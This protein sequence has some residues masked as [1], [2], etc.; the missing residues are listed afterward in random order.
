MVI[1]PRYSTLTHSSHLEN[2][3]TLHYNVTSLSKLL[4]I[5]FKE[6][7][8]RVDIYWQTENSSNCNFWKLTETRSIVQNCFYKA[9][10]KRCRQSF[11]GPNGLV[12]EINN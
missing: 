6:T 8:A 7:V 10:F 4:Y 3:I 5:R 12:V 1:I 11:V 9:T 2:I